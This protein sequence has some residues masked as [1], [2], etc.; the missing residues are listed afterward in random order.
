MLKNGI[1]DI[2]LMIFGFHTKSVPCFAVQKKTFSILLNIFFGLFYLHTLA[3][4]L[5]SFT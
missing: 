1:N 5:A 3:V 4:A 2:V